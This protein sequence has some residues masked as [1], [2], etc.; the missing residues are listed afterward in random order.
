MS[1]PIRAGQ[2]FVEAAKSDPQTKRAIAK[3]EAY[4]R[5]LQK[6]SPYFRSVTAEIEKDRNRLCAEIGRLIQAGAR[7]A[8]REM[9]AR[10][11][12]EVR[13][14]DDLMRLARLVE[15][16][17]ERIGTMTWNEIH[18]EAIA[19]AD[20]ITARRKLEMEAAPE[21]P[22]AKAP[23][24]QNPGETI[25]AGK[26][27]RGVTLM[28]TAR[29]MAEKDEEVAR[30]LVRKWH[31]TRAHQLP[32]PIGKKNGREH[33]FKPSALCDYFESVGELMPGGKSK[34]LKALGLC[35]E[36]GVPNKPLP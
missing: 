19:W 3:L 21:P 35:W 34:F 8:N 27:V 12:P 6:L 17:P 32:E 36:V 10:H 1:Q 15:I 30:R 13:D 4:S 24:P 31:N 14:L 29:M 22:S 25:G 2:A 28:R 18:I 20:R 23:S 33:L 9:K 7:Q 11:L 26:Q 5:A 16:P